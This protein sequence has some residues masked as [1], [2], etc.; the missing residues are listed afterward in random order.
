MPEV[1]GLTHVGSFFLPAGDFGGPAFHGFTYGGTA[2]SYHPA[3][4]SLYLVGHPDDQLVAEVSIPAMNGTA[5]V[6]QNFHDVTD[7]LRTTVNPGDPNFKTVGGTLVVGDTLVSTV[8]S[9][10]DGL[11]SQV[12]SH[13]LHAKDFTVPGVEGPLRVGPLGAGYYDGYMAHV[14]AG[15]QTALGGPALTGNADIAV[16]SRTSLGPSAHSF[17]PENISPTGAQPL[18]Y[19]TES[20]PTLGPWDEAGLF[21]GGS[22]T[23]RGLCIW[24]DSALFFG[25]HGD[26]FCYGSGTNNPALHGTLVGP[27]E[28]GV[29]YC[30]DPGN[31]S[32]GVHGYPYHA[33]CVAYRLSDLADVHAGSKQP[34]EIAPY[35]SWP[36][37]MGA[38]V[39]GA[40]ID[41]ATGLIYVSGIQEHGL[42][43]VVHVFTA[44]TTA[45]DPVSIVCPGDQTAAAL[46]PAGIVVDYPA[47]VVTGG[48]VP[49]VT[50]LPA[51]GSVFPVGD[52]L[53]T[54]TVTDAATSSSDSC[55]F[56][57][58]VSA[59]AP[60]PVSLICPGNQT[61]AALLPGGIVVNYPAAQVIGGVDPVVTSL[62]AS[63]SLFPVGVTLVTVTATDAD[64][65]SSDSCSFTV[66]VE[67]PP[68]PRQITSITIGGTIRR[69]S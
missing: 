37:S 25:R 67:A 24:G 40:T 48:L 9:A 42:L 50:S 43:P 19:Y 39:G 59:P 21:Y 56:T 69:R 60:S 47:A 12:V 61:A 1:T 34:W 41:P 51:N 2:L 3:N 65:S 16:I 22:D 6:L 68:P 33:V 57:V 36:L 28:P 8:F 32:K 35:A 30:Y 13:F 23:V 5:T 29:I 44:E 17:D 18:V 53:V 64:T 4:N 45:V 10:Y 26:S 46:V 11:G 15:W 58:T 49:V 55:T 31:G 66:T 62:P 7:G 14:P 54:V 52:T 38:N 63:G 20:H 27:S